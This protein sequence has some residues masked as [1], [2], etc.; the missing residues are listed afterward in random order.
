MI[1]ECDL[2]DTKNVLVEQYKEPM[3]PQCQICHVCSNTYFLNAKNNPDNYG[4]SGTVVILHAICWGINYLAK[5]IKE[6]KYHPIV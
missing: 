6:N 2:C 1:D 4:G 5:L 3:V